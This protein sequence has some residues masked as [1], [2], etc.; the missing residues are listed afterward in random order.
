MFRLALVFAGFE[1]VNAFSGQ[2]TCLPAPAP[3]PLMCEEALTQSPAE[4]TRGY[5]GRKDP[6]DTL[7]HGDF[8]S[9]GMCQVNVHWHLGSE[10]LSKG[11]YD[12]P[13]VEFAAKYGKDMHV[14][15]GYFCN[16]YN[17][18]D[19][20]FTTEYEW[21]YCKDM[22]VGFTYEIHWPFSSAGHCGRLSDGLGGVFCH[23][24]TPK[25]IA[26]QAQVF[27]IVNDNT[28]DVEDLINGMNMTLATDVAKYVGSTT[29][30]KYG[31]D[32]CSPYA[33]ISWHVDRK[34][35]L[36]SAKSFDAMCG[37]MKAYGMEVDLSPHGSRVIVHSDYVSNKIH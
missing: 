31:N 34:C 20:K 24:P 23:S 16:D 2:S 27:T 28:Y 29:G 30:T 9:E 3:M 10:H 19:A 25:K 12:V 36:V 37:K 17:P 1:L 6:V 13:G 35:H 26:V 21:K 11:E 8:V 7:L 32:V 4:V 14:V 5:N 18:D 33:P 15:P 22:H